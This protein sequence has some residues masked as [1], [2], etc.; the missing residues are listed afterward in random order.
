[1]SILPE[2]FA[3]PVAGRSFV[4]CGLAVVARTEVGPPFRV[5]VLAKIL[6]IAVSVGD[7]LDLVALFS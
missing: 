2:V 6:I 7:L 3:S 4:L 5:F 1:M